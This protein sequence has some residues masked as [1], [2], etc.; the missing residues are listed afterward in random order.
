MGLGSRRG[1]VGGKKGRQGGRHET[2]TDAKWTKV[3]GRLSFCG[4]K[5]ANETEIK[6]EKET[7]TIRERMREN[8]SEWDRDQLKTEVQI[9]S[10]I[11]HS[12]KNNN[13]CS[14]IILR[15]VLCVRVPVWC[16]YTWTRKV[17]RQM[18]LYQRTPLS[19]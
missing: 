8:E 18:L 7:A 12:K 19:L 10:L 16:A 14:S 1:R 15:I 13:K 17:C 11:Q 4:R 5:R 3:C 6:L 9:V 2:Q